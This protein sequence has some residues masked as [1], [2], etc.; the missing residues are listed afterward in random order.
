MA[1]LKAD[2]PL[3]RRIVL[4]FLDFLN[5]VEPSSVS[6]VE[7]LEVARD[8]LSEAFKIGSSSTSSVPKSDSLVELFSSQKGKNSEINSD[9]IHGESR[10]DTPRALSCTDNVADDRTLADTPT[11]GV[12]ED[13]LFGQFFGA[14]E[15]THYFG[16]TA[17]GDDEQAL[18]RATDLFHKA[19]TEMKKSGGEEFDLKTLAD[20]FK[21]QGNKAMQSKLY[22]EAI[23]LY[24]VAIAISND[25]AVYYCNRAAA[26]TQITQYTEAIQ[27]C[28]KAIA[29]DPN[30]SKAYSRLG[31]IYNAQ[32]KYLDAVDKGYMKALELDPNN[33]SIKR[34]IAVAGQKLLEG[35]GQSSGSWM[36]TSEGAW[37]PIHP[38]SLFRNTLPDPFD[39]PGIMGDMRRGRPGNSASEQEIGIMGGMRRG[40]PGNNPAGEPEIGIMGD[41]RRGRP[42]NN[43]A[44]EPEIRSGGP[45]PGEPHGVLRSAYQMFSER[46]APHDNSSGN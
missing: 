30:Y 23:E 18:D 27:D 41:M 17:N 45:M 1:N 14:L 12:P 29:I 8:C 37:S 22:T 19:L 6:D 9:R 44:G 38:Y 31:F 42:G 5:S 7:S 24:T 10:P 16:T 3:C 2:S 21:L 20:N 33:E 32:G 28:R 36:E 25:N 35:H 34:N 46:G 43:P 26:Y 13:E 15:K 39:L 4:S 40:W 11:T